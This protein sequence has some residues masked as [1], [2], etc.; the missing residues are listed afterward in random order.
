MIVVVALIILSAIIL[1]AMHAAAPSYKDILNR[2][3]VVRIHN[4]M[5]VGLCGR[6]LALIYQE[7]GNCKGRKLGN[8]NNASNKRVDVSLKLT[9][10]IRR[11][12]RHVWATHRDV[13]TSHLNCANPRLLE[14][15]AL[16][17]FPG[18][19]AQYWHR[20][21]E[22]DT[23]KSR[24]VSIGVALQDITATMGVLEAVKKTH[25][26]LA[27]VSEETERALGEKMVCSKGDIV[28][29]SSSVHH[30]GTANSSDVTRVVLNITLASDGPL[31][32]GPTYSLL[33]RYKIGK[34]FP[35]IDSI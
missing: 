24:L 32:V 8:I 11:V 30:R 33:P 16:I 13:W 27:D 29:W 21:V 17:T 15:S 12:I 18:A 5:P 9:P 2:D 14:C 7:F 31:P 34:E 10:T 20:D 25:M 1:Y 19:G 23:T 3:G 4:S 35:K 26:T 6:T 22:Y 28:A